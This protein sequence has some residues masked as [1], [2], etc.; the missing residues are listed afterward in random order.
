LDTKVEAPIVDH[1]E[2][3][4]CRGT[5]FLIRVARDIQPKLRTCF[6]GPFEGWDYF[7]NDTCPV[8]VSGRSE[9]KTIIE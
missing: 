4:T 9:W 7:D 1:A 2:S 3:P 5:V 6:F 8:V